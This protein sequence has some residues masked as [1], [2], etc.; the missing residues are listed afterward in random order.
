MPLHF[1]P[2]TT[3]LYGKGLESDR[4]TLSSTGALVSYSGKCTGRVPKDKRVVYDHTTKDI[5]WG[6]INMKLDKD[7]FN[8]YCDYSRDSLFHRLEKDLDLYQ[9]DILAG[10]DYP[11]KVRVY[12]VNP[13]HALFLKNM[14]KYSD[15]PFSKVDFTIYNTGHICLETVTEKL[16]ESMT[17]DSSL[18]ENLIAI[19]FTQM[20]MCIF[21][22]EYAGEMKKG[23]LTLAMYRSVLIPDHLPLHSSCNIGPNNDVT[24][25]FGLSGTGKTTLSTEPNRYLVGD[26]EHVWTEKGVYNIENGNYAKCIGLNPDSEP[27]IFNAIKFGA[28][29]ENVVLQGDNN[30]VDFS[31]ISITANTRVAYPTTHIPNAVLPAVVDSH[32]KNIILLTCDAFGVLPPVAKLTDDQAVYFFVKGYTSKM[33]GTEVGVREPKAVFSPCFG[34]PFLVWHPNVYGDILREKLNKH[35][36]NVWLVNTGWTNGPYGIGKR[37]SI[38]H[39]RKIIDSI[40]DDSLLD[41]EYETYPFFNIQIPKTCH[42]IPYSTLNPLASG[43]ISVADL[44]ELKA[45]FN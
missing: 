10:H 23:I 22:S 24:V 30:V 25:F 17:P 18:T 7:L 4:I 1:N 35:K 15:E 34:A 9:I 16:P 2:S 12:C 45:K 5:D 37:M 31:D 11:V 39:T 36:S 21:G 44:D 29:L 42:E 32:P 26:D 38:K 13:Y 41:V 28:V 8:Y 14:F 33:P 20:K 3:F 19:D 43:N 27:E 40:H 6:V